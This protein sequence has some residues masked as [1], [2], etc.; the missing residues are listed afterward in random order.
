MGVHRLQFARAAKLQAICIE[1]PKNKE[2]FGDLTYMAKPGNQDLILTS[3]P[4]AFGAV[5]YCPA[6]DLDIDSESRD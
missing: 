3:G 6:P 4:A 1:G 2:N 5:N